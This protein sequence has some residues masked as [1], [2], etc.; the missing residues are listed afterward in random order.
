MEIDVGYS[1]V[2]RGTLCIYFYLY[3][4]KYES[5]RKMLARISNKK[6]YIILKNESFP[7]VF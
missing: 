1:F 2:I 3:F 6:L 7:N 5:E 4:P